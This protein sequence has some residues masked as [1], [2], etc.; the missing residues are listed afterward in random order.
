MHAALNYIKLIALQ[1]L[2]LY[3]APFIGGY[4]GIKSELARPRKSGIKNICIDDVRL[5]FSPL[6]GAIDEVQKELSR[7]RRH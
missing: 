2:R 7:V 1:D 6:I 5:Y 4:R 3:F